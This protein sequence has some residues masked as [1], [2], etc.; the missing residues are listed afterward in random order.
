MP[1]LCPPNVRSKSA[2]CPLYVHSLP[3]LCP[4]YVRSRTAP[5]CPQ[6]CRLANEASGSRKQRRA[7]F[8]LHTDLQ[9]RLLPEP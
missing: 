5:A 9:A 7:G 4:L 3:A 8:A 1:A 2:L 6:V